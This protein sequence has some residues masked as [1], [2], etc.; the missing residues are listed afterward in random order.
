MGICNGVYSLLGHVRHV[1]EVLWIADLQICGQQQEVV[2]P[3]R[4]SGTLK[5]NACKQPNRLLSVVSGTSPLNL[6]VG[7]KH[8]VD[9]HYYPHR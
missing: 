2:F 7:D 3:K 4:G 1:L 8:G 5:F 9:H 6:C